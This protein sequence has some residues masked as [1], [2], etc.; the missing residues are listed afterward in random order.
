MNFM[1]GVYNVFH[2]LATSIINNKLIVFFN[3]PIMAQKK[4]PRSFSHLSTALLLIQSQMQSLFLSQWSDYM[5]EFKHIEQI[6]KPNLLFYL[7]IHTWF[8]EQ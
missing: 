4:T 5:D 2:L 1:Q 3:F 6:T 7:H 8:K